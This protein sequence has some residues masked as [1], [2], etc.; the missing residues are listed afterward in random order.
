M[1]RILSIL[2]AV[3]CFCGCESE[4]RE[5]WSNDSYA[6]IIA[7]TGNYTLYSGT[8]SSEIDLSGKGF[9]TDDILYQMELYGWMGIQSIR[10]EDDPESVTV[11]QRSEVIIPEK[12][13]YKTQINL[14]VPYPEYGKDQT[15]YLIQQ[16]GR[17]NISMEPYQFHYKVDSRGDIEL[18]NIDD[19]QMV[20][21][22]GILK[23]VEIHFEGEYIHFK[24]ETSL[25]DWSTQTWQDGTMNLTY[26]HN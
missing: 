6:T 10:Q 1:K 14:Y 16:T 19:R 9:V 13:E 24:A 11:L 2:T 4:S 26:R 3:I 20:G 21:Y 18:F 7:I 5:S 23:N 17:C 15:D 8:W 25:Y 12:P 22:G